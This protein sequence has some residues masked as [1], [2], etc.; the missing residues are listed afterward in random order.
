MKK[1]FFIKFWL[2]N[3]LVRNIHLKKKMLLIVF[4]YQTGLKDCLKTKGIIKCKLQTLVDHHNL[5]YHLL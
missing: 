3:L 2:Q 1:H 5:V 4:E